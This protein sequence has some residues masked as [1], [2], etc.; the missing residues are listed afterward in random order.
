MWPFRPSVKRKESLETR[1]RRS[2]DRTQFLFAAVSFAAIFFYKFDPL[3]EVGL[4]EVSIF[5]PARA[6]IS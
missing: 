2:V 1:L 3:P 4:A 5:E 6:L